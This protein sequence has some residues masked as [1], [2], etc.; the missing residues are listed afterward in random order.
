MYSEEKVID[1]IEILE[2]GT[3]FIR[4]KTKVFRDGEIIAETYH[5]S[6]YTPEEE[7]PFINDNITGIAS[8]I[9]TKEV[10]DKYKS[11]RQKMLSENLDKENI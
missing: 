8:I 11:E 3:M 1:K 5:R 6:S 4:E 10:V 2:D 7:I 9:R